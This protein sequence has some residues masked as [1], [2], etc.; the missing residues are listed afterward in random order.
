MMVTVTIDRMLR[1]VYDTA[2]CAVAYPRPGTRTL[3]GAIAPGFQET[4][5]GDDEEEQFA[6]S[7]ESVNTT[8]WRALQRQLVDSGAHAV[9][10]QETWVTQDAIPAASAWA[11]RRGWKS[12]W[13]AA[14]PGPNGG[15]SGGTA[16][17]ARDYL[18]LRYPPPPPRARTSGAQGTR[19][20]RSLMP[21]RT[22][23]CY[24]HRAT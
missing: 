2:R 4:R 11:K 8:G 23:R 6:L 20:P 9:M 10:A 1:R 16:V 19:W 13:S 12:I 15:A 3:R 18:G 7:I 24:C 22:A 21:Q 17:F 5:G 14:K